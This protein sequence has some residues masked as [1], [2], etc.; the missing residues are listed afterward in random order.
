LV[1]CDLG[2]GVSL[3]REHFFLEGERLMWSPEI[4]GHLRDEENKP[5]SKVAFP[6]HIF[7]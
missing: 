7:F 4:I 5:F 6:S 2:V 3:N 1:G